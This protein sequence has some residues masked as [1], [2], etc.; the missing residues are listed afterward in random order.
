MLLSGS[1]TLQPNISKTAMT[2]I[3]PKFLVIYKAINLAVS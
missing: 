3:Y 1:E 2:E